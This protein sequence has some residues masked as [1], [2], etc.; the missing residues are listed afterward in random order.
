[1]VAVPDSPLT[2]LRD[3]AQIVESIITVEGCVVQAARVFRYL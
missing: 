3:T 1:M 2:D